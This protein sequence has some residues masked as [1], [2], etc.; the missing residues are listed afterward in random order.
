MLDS[1]MNEVAGALRYSLKVTKRNF[2]KTYNNSLHYLE[3]PYFLFV[4]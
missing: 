3:S 1:E 4:S 2:A